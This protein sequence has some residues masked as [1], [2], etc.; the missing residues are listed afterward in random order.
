LPTKASAQAKSRTPDTPHL[1]AT[2]RSPA[3]RLLQICVDQM[4][5]ERHKSIVGARLP[6]KAS[7]QAKSRTPDTPH[8]PATK[9]SPASRLL[10]I[11]VDQ[12]A[13]ERHK[14]IVGARLP[15]IAVG[16]AAVLGRLTLSPK[17]IQPLRT[18]AAEWGLRLCAGLTGIY[19]KT[20]GKKTA[21]GPG[22][23]HP[24]TGCVHAG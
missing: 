2:Q 20:R 10:Q 3:S 16:R 14:S 15:A 9:R 21:S 1:P 7:A 24:G 18:S 6:T 11:C 13:R 5:R 22:A 4:A 12:M 19:L 8:L 23:A 17:R